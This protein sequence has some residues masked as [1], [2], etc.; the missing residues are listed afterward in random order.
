MCGLLRY[1][2]YGTRD[3][4]QKDDERERVFVRA[5]RCGW[6]RSAVVFLIRMISK[7]YETKKQVIGEDPDLE[8][9]RRTL[10]RVIEWNRDGT[11]IRE[12]LKGLELERANRSATPV[13]W[14]QGI[15][16][17]RGF[18]EGSVGRNAITYSRRGDPNLT[19]WWRALCQGTAV[20][21]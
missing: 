13:P 20:A 10:N 3:A 2:L 18:K 5:E 12:I 21:R 7:K 8:K 16:G 1:S 14:K 11:T 6:G 17:G 9:S 19:R 15:H 4:A